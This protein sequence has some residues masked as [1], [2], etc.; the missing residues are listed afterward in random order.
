MDPHPSRTKKTNCECG[1]HM[2]L[3]MNVKLSSGG[4]LASQR[5]WMPKQSKLRKQKKNGVVHNGVVTCWNSYSFPPTFQGINRG[6][7]QEALQ[8]PLLEEGTSSISIPRFP[9]HPTIWTA[10]V[11]SICY[12]KP[13]HPKGYDSFSSVAFPRKHC[14]KNRDSL[15]N[16]YF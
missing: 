12:H 10:E 1:C 13:L 15:G 14:T 6:V 8:N 11:W 9:G 3:F 16:P 2:F 7:T 5:V 4:N